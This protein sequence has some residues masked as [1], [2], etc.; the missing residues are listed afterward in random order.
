MSCRIARNASLDEAQLSD[1]EAKGYYKI[2][3]DE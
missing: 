3:G 2:K 1:G